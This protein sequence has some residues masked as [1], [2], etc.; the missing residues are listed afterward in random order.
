[1]S[2]CTDATDP[3]Y[4]SLAGTLKPRSCTQNEFQ[5]FQCCFYNESP[6]GTTAPLSGFAK[7][8]PISYSR[9]QFKGACSGMKEYRPFIAAPATTF[10]MNPPFDPPTDATNITVLEESDS[11]CTS[12]NPETC[13]V[14]DP[15][16]IRCCTEQAEEPKLVG[17]IPVTGGKY[18]AQYQCVGVSACTP[19]YSAPHAGDSRCYRTP[20]KADVSKSGGYLCEC[21]GDGG[22]HIVQG[23]SMGLGYSPYCYRSPAA[24]HGRAMQPS[25]TVPPHYYYCSGANGSWKQ[26]TS[27]EGCVLTYSDEHPQLYHT[28]MDDDG[29][30]AQGR[31]ADDYCPWPP[32]Q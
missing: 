12:V 6:D 1:M 5:N 23:A 10:C 29:K 17:C 2:D 13:S 4:K 25:Y 16:C 9:C 21:S 15:G 24:C 19:G 18:I 32:P 26:C 3:L 28:N 27:V 31:G 11:T 14:S 8:A 30:I 22:G 20:P 7:G